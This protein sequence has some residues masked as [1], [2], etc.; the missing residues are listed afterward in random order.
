MK[1]S[2]LLV[3]GNDDKHVILSLLKYYDVPDVFDVTNCDGIDNLFRELEMRL[4]TPTMY[5]NIGVVVDADENIQ[6]RYNAIY[7]KLKDTGGYD[8]S[9]VT[10]SGKGTLIQPLDDNYPFV[11]LWLMPDNR[12]DGMLEDFVMALADKDDALMNE[13]DTVLTSLEAR[14]LNKYSTSVHRSKA[15]IHTYLA[16]QEKPGMPM[17]QAITAKV[18][19]ADSESAKV[20]V[21]WVR[22]LFVRS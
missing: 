13:A 7:G 17:G 6:G 18:L 2:N 15:K 9:H 12:N 11:G 3:E 5:K 19:H 16:W 1:K 14:A 22:N 10:I 8:M 21:E 20:F 4:S